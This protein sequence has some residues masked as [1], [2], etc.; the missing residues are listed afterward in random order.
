MRGRHTLA[1][2]K[3]LDV[4]D[5]VVDSTE[6]YVDVACRLVHDQPFRESVEKRIAERAP[7]LFN[8]VSAISEISDVFEQ[9]I[10]EAY[11]A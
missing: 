11:Q 6:A 7:S 10:N 3:R 4:M 5:C 8:D 9:M 2:Y 1:F